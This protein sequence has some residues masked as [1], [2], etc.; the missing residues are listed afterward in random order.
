VNC[1]CTYAAGGA[2][3]GGIVIVRYTKAQVD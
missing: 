2:G 3:A 1:G